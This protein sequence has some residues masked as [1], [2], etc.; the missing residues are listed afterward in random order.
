MTQDVSAPLSGTVIRINVGQ[1]DMVKED[2]V[3]MT[4]EAMKMETEIYSPCEGTV[5]NI[6]VDVGSQVEED[7]VLFQIA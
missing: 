6:Q 7:D 2:D 1:G 3:V 5:D 4:M